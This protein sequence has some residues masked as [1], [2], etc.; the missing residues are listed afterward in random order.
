MFNKLVI[1]DALQR[2]YS[3]NLEELKRPEL[4]GIDLD[5]T[6]VV[7]RV[8]E[9]VSDLKKIDDN[10]DKLRI[11]TET[12]NSITNLA[13]SIYDNVVNQTLTFNAKDNPNSSSQYQTILTNLNSSYDNFIKITGPLLTEIK[14]NSIMPGQIKNEIDNFNKFKKDATRLVS[15]L[16]EKKLEAE[17]I[18]RNASGIEATKISSNI[19]L[20][21]SNDHK[22]EAKK[23]LITAMLIVGF[24][25]L[26]VFALFYGWL[27]ISSV[28]V[29]NYD[30]KYKIIQ[31][32]VFE[33]IILS[34]L[35]FLLHQSV[36]NYKVHR[37][38]SVINKHR[39]NALVVYPQI[40]TA[41]E[42]SE[43]R[44]TIV[45]QAAKSIFENMPSGYLEFDDDPRP[46]NPTAIINKIIDRK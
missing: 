37:H 36:K 13:N 23:W 38:L 32:V 30:D 43:A 1:R 41:G 35:Y 7:K 15:E 9:V 10:Q 22:G 14:L 6:D 5:F 26:T 40:I 39:H 12:E 33:L 11:S 17:N 20:N 28:H 3:I 16:Q 24:L 27:P 34:S 31:S 42:D 19:F 21:Q 29:E 25:I 2:L 4:L 44:N 45:S 18:I 8:D 46:V